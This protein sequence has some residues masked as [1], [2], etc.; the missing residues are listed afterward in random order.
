MINHHIQFR[1]QTLN[2][3]DIYDYDY[4]YYYYYYYNNILLSIH[5]DKKV[6][7]HCFSKISTNIIDKNIYYML[8]KIS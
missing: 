4:E 7:N 1:I 6:Y 5:Y 3:Y 2:Y 8:N